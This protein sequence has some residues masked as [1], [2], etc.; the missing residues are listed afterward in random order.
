MEPRK[1]T[2]KEGQKRELKEF[3]EWMRRIL[4]GQKV[5]DNSLRE[6][7]REYSACY[8]IWRSTEQIRGRYEKAQVIQMAFFQAGK[9][10]WQMEEF[11]G[12]V[13]EEMPNIE[14][15]KAIILQGY[16]T[17]LDLMWMEYFK[18][19]SHCKECLETSKEC[20]EEEWRMRFLMDAASKS[21][22]FEML[23]TIYV[24]SY[25][26]L[27]ED[28]PKG[29]DCQKLL[30]R[31]KVLQSAMKRG[32]FPFDALYIS[33]KKRKRKMESEIEKSKELSRAMQS[34]MMEETRRKLCDEG[35]TREELM[36]TYRTFAQEIQEKILDR[37]PRESSVL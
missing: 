10:R 21:E 17:Y 23:A 7:Q 2:K 9:M 33:L 24:K 19:R 27:E 15:K 8:E 16:D 6:F 35:S 32:D 5:L 1:T 31:K 34:V 14:E 13:E 20:T 26:I 22:W 18:L 4:S 37:F 36:D 11:Q 12:F 29:T 30:S 28:I 3:Y 25:H